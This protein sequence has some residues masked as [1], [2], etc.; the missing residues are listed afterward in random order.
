MSNASSGGVRSLSWSFDGRFLVGASEEVAAGGGAGGR[1]EG[2]EI[3]H[4]ETGEVVYTIATGTS[5]VP[6]VEWH[7]HRYWL[8]YTQVEDLTGKSVLKIIGPAGGPSI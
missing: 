1:S 6:A 3:Y 5:S 4:A 7:P 2:V 8:A